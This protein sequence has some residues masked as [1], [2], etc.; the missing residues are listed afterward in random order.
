MV[1]AV[2]WCKCISTPPSCHHRTDRIFVRPHLH[3][4]FNNLLLIAVSMKFFAHPELDA[5][6]KEALQPIFRKVVIEKPKASR[7]GMCSMLPIAYEAYLQSRVKHIGFAWIIKDHP[8][9]SGCLTTDIHLG[10]VRHTAQT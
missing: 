6:K 3:P 10:R 1:K 8:K 9:T 5:F 4:Q 7:S 2:I